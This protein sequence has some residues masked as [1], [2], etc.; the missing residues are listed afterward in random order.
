MTFSTE[1]KIA[2]TAALNGAACYRVPQPGLLRIS[3]EGRL[4]F[5][6]RQTTNDVR[7]LQTGHALLTV[8]TSATARILDVWWLLISPDGDAVDAITL[9]GRG[10]VTAQYLQRRIFFMDRVTVSDLSADHAQGWVTGPQAAEVLRQAGLEPPAPGEVLTL[11]GPVRVLAQEETRGGGYLVL[12]SPPALE[13]LMQ[14]LAEGGA[15]TL[16][17]ETCEVLRVEAG[18]P[19]PARELT[20]AYTPLETNLDRAIHGAKGCYTGQEI[21]ARQITYDKIA[22]RLVGLRLAAPAV[23][24]ATVLADGRPVGEV[25]SAAVSSRFGPV[26]LAV[27][28]RP[29][30]APGTTITVTGDMGEVT[31]NVV[32]LPF[33]DR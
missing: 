12:G 20:E 6:Q 22:R 2:Y 10:S 21:I 18:L 23:A 15:V 11:P 24:G 5:I 14:R 29:H 7:L 9:P 28:R 17:D 31:G 19:G 30:F 3:G 16:D 8:L 27:L 1:A 33:A 26:A 13:T 25:T 4:D 32:A